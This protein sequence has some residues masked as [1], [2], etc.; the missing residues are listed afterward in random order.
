ML[1]TVIHCSR[2]L[3]KPFSTQVDFLS[4]GWTTER[5]AGPG[6]IIRLSRE[7]VNEGLT[8][9]LYRH[10]WILLNLRIAVY[11][12]SLCF[13]C[14]DQWASGQQCMEVRKAI[15]L[16]RNV[17]RMNRKLTMNMFWLNDHRIKTTQPISMIFVSFVSEGNAL[18]DKI[19][20]AKKKKKIKVS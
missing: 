7:M 1:K 10:V 8:Y 3:G 17:T 16:D 9:C 20:N 4:S 19:K 18:S 11:K 12:F 13:V 5:W 14:T 6:K 2:Q 15:A